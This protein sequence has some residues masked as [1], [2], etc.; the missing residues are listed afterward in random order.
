MGLG[1][2]ATRRN[3]TQA[4]SCETGVQGATT[5]TAAKDANVDALRSACRRM[6]LLGVGRTIDCD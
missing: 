3:P 1:D 5:L 6:G 4:R 2:G